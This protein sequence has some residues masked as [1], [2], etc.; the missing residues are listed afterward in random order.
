MPLVF[1]HGVNVREG[2]KYKKEVTQRDYYFRNIFFNL[3]G[4][5]S[6]EVEI[7]SPY[8]GDLATN[9][10][11]GTPFLPLKGRTSSSSPAYEKD[12]KGE[13]SGGTRAQ[14]SSSTES[15]DEHSADDEHLAGPTFL[16]LAREGSLEELVNMVIATA[17]ESANDSIEQAQELSLLARRALVLNRKFEEMDDQK[18]WL[19]GVTDDSALLQKLEDEL[20]KEEAAASGKSDAF[21]HLRVA[22]DWVKKNYGTTTAARN[23][24]SIRK[25]QVQ[26]G[27][28]SIVQT[29]K[30]S[31][32]KVR[33][34]RHNATSHLAAA[35][36]TSP[37]RRLFHE[38]MFL[39]I[40]DSFLYFGQ[41][42]T[43]DAPGPIVKRIIDGLDDAWKLKKEAKDSS[44][45][46]V[47]AHSMGGNIMTDIVSHF[48]PEIEIDV[49]ITVATQFPLFADLH[50]FP[51]LDTRS[52]PI[53]KPPNVK[54]WINFYD[55]NDFFGFTAHPMFE[56]IEDVDFASGRVGITTHADCFKFVSLYERMGE[57]ILSEAVMK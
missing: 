12:S 31:V 46:I 55:V 50:M 9:I 48:R 35:T 28:H 54:R 15:S 51:G 34:I 27:I 10:T 13:C 19:D 45:L 24:L 22:A 17:S 5:Q 16:E 44:R 29:A 8:W 25:Q 56:G 40:G 23:R 7:I 33:A 39:F 49:L 20:Q 2:D 43:P 42:G 32:R 14:S 47:V 11:V 38:K 36:F 18:S 57:A 52:R 21:M 4:H 26:S 1:V 30:N 6:Q 53:K 41:R 37:I 3:L